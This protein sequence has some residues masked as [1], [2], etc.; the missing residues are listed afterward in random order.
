MA[1]PLVWLGAEDKS[2]EFLSFVSTLETQIIGT[3]PTILSITII[4]S[5]LYSLDSI[6]ITRKMVIVHGEPLLVASGCTAKFLLQHCFR[7]QVESPQ[8]LLLPSQIPVMPLVLWDSVHVS[9][10]HD[11]SSRE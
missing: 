9:P 6:N 10:T 2:T 3:S 11:Q 5:P 7:F 4:L 1:L 8:H